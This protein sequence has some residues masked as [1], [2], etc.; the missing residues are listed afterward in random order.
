MGP[1]KSHRRRGRLVIKTKACLCL[2]ALGC[3]SHFK[4]KEN[5]VLL[6]LVQK[7]RHL[8]LVRGLNRLFN[9]VCHSVSEE[10]CGALLLPTRKKNNRQVVIE[11]DKIK[12]T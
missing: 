11:L 5:S 12:A 4:E 1:L 2:V 7:R 3:K 8:K 10:L 6:T 9:S